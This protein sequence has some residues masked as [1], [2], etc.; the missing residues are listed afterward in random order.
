MGGKDGKEGEKKEKKDDKHVELSMQ[1]PEPVEI[2][3]KAEH[4]G[5]FIFLH[6]FSDSGQEAAEYMGPTIPPNVKLVCPTANKTTVVQ[7]LQVTSWFD[8]I[9]FNESDPQDVNGIKQAAIMVNELIEAEIAS[10][11]PANRIILGGFSQ[12]GAL[13]IHTA[14]HSQHKLAGVIAMSCW[15]PLHH[16]LQNTASGKNAKTPFLQCHGKLDTVVTHDWGVLSSKL[17]KKILDN[18]RFV[19][20]DHMGHDRCEAELKEVQEFVAQNLPSL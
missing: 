2:P 1:L 10:G 13:T 15:V 3:A 16:E 18:H 7:G 5:T 11:I 17:L 6:G 12:G 9:S 4:D 19:S 20:Y 8:L 14:M